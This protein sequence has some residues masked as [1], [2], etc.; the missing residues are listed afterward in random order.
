MKFLVIRLPQDTTYHLAEPDKVSPWTSRTL[1]GAVF[2]TGVR[3]ARD[4][5]RDRIAALPLYRG[6]NEAHRCRRCDTAAREPE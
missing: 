4:A 2:C 6:R 5:E 3:V 1:C